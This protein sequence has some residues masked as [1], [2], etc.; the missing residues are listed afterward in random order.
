MVAARFK[1]SIGVLLLSAC[2]E[3]SPIEVSS[4]AY[5]TDAKCWLNSKGNLSAFVVMVAAGSNHVPYLLSSKCVPKVEGLKEGAATALSTGAVHLSDPSQ[6]LKK[7]I[8]LSGLVIN[9]EISDLPGPDSSAPVFYVIAKV[10]ENIEAFNGRFSVSGVE[11]SVRLPNNYISLVEQPS[12]VRLNA[13]LKIDA[14]L[15]Q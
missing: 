14:E 9:S 12:H 3:V 7:S 10:N 11:K 15:S 8:G 1:L 6:L 2:G 13:A 4:T 5:R